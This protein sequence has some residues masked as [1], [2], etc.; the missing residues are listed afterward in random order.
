MNMIIGMNIHS[1]I[2][3]STAKTVPFRAGTYVEQISITRSR[4]VTLI[5]ETDFPNDYTQNQVIISFS[6]GQLTS[7]GEGETTPVIY[8]KKTDSAGLAL[9]NINFHNTYPQ[10]KITAALAADFYSSNMAAYGA[11]SL[12]SRTPS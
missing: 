4:K 6:N 1:V 3:G 7:A 2:I 10:T 9:Y 8:A 11:V 5:G 12:D